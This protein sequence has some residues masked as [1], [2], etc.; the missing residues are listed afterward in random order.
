MLAYQKYAKEVPADLRPAA[1][2]STIDASIKLADTFPG[3]PQKYPVLAQT[4]PGAYF[5]VI[6]S[7]ILSAAVTRFRRD[8]YQAV[9][10]EDI[11]AEKTGIAKPGVPLVTQLYPAQVAERDAK[12]G[13]VGAMVLGVERPR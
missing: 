8:G 4:A 5:A 7:V 2:K 1:L 13:D 11:A 3:H 10:I 9:R 6:L 12:E